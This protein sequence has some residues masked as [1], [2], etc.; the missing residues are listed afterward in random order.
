MTRLIISAEARQDL[1]DIGDY[2][3]YN[4]PAAAT[5]FIVR[6]EQCCLEIAQHPGIGRGR[7]ELQPGLR[8]LAEGRY[9][10][11]FRHQTIHRT[12]EIVRIVHGYRKME[13]IF[14]SH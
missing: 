13:K 1:Q 9:L 3:A 2:I 4:N 11:Y 14:K 8:S 12:V 6:L 5:S 10:I 7:D